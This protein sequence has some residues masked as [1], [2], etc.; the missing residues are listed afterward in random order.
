VGTALAQRGDL[1]GAHAVARR[2][3]LLIAP[4]GVVRSSIRRCPVPARFVPREFVVPRL[5]ETERFR[6]RTLTIHDVVKDYDAVM[7]SRAHL[8]AALPWGWPPDDLTLEQDLID[9]AWHQ[10]EFDRATSFAFAVMSPDERRLLGCVYLEPAEKDGYD[11]EVAM[12]VRADELATGLE[13]VLEATVRRWVAE[14]W[15][16]ARV[17]YPGRDMAWEAWDA[18]PERTS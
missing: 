4:A 16:F 12:W 15:P 11:A 5:L 1:E 17:G 14:A 9:L 3:A 2:P 6:V 13:D 18:L 7:T 8:R 10:K